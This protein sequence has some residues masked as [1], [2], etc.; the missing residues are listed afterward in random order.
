[1]KKIIYKIV[2][3]IVCVAVPIFL[4]L[5]TPDLQ[6]EGK[7]LAET[8]V[9]LVN[10]DEGIKVEDRQY[11]FGQILTESFV[12][13]S[14]FNAKNNN[15]ADAFNALENGSAMY[16]IVFD[17]DF[18][19][20]INSYDSTNQIKGKVE[21]YYNHTYDTSLNGN[22]QS[23]NERNRIFEELQNEISSV[24]TK[25][26]VSK[27]E[28][29]KEMLRKDIDSDIA[30]SDGIKKTSVQNTANIAGAINSANQH[31][32]GFKN[33]M[34]EKIAI[35]DENIKNSKEMESGI[36]KKAKENELLVNSSEDF[37]EVFKTGIEQN[38]STNKD[39]YI[40]SRDLFMGENG[41]HS[42]ITKTV[43]P[44]YAQYDMQY[45]HNIG[46]FLNII[47][48]DEKGFMNIALDVYEE[49][50]YTELKEYLKSM[51]ISAL[52]VETKKINKI[53]LF[54]EAE[55]NEIV[56]NA[57]TNAA[58]VYDE[59]E[60]SY[61]AG[62]YTNL[63]EI[64]QGNKG[65]LLAEI[66]EEATKSSINTAVFQNA[67]VIGA[68][69]LADGIPVGMVQIQESQLADFNAYN[70]FMAILEEKT[71]PIQIPYSN[72]KCYYMNS[73]NNTNFNTLKNII[74]SEYV[75]YGG[76]YTA[77]HNIVNENSL[78]V[79]GSFYGLS[80]LN[81]SDAKI[82]A[83]LKRE[84]ADVEKEVNLLNAY[85]S[86]LFFNALEKEAVAKFN[87]KFFE[88]GSK[89][90]LEFNDD[91]LLFMKTNSEVSSSLLKEYEKKHDRNLT[92]LHE[93]SAFIV[94]EYNKSK[95]H[96]ASII[97][98]GNINLSAYATMSDNNRLVKEENTQIIEHIAGVKKNNTNINGVAQK[99]NK[100][101]L[102]SLKELSDANAVQ[103]SFV[104]DYEKIL[105]VANVNGVSNTNFFDFI[106]DPI[107][108][109]KQDIGMNI[110]TTTSYFIIFWL[111]AG[112]FIINGL[113]DKF[114]KQFLLNLNQ[115]DFSDN[116]VIGFFN[117]HLIYIS[118]L[119]IF[120]SA[121]ALAIVEKFEIQNAS[122]F[123][124]EMIVIAVLISYIMRSLIKKSRFI[125]YSIILF[126]IAI[127][128]IVLFASEGNLANEI[129]ALPLITLDHFIMSNIYEV[130]Y[131]NAFIY[132]LVIY[133]GIA[134]FIV[135][136]DFVI[137]KNNKR[138]EL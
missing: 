40:M 90:M 96:N 36:V 31:I 24:Y 32:S 42:Y 16:V 116:K 95:E 79:L 51:Q 89:N 86:S 101:Y 74:K 73:V 18:S 23:E 72:N 55:V 7:E 33:E 66:K 58:D 29:T 26:I 128:Y 19:K 121:Y 65:I 47:D 25:T 133:I 11:N 92:K 64:Y 85:A 53:A 59:N 20:A 98:S 82:L 124:G 27:V 114:K 75:P 131:P 35:V 119:I 76:G 105:E 60:I 70:R 44:I 112:I 87:S 34:A 120:G 115:K 127:M 45:K 21:Y 129:L 78:G 5:Q 106:S 122:I 15:F 68:S 67:N 14:E 57:Y 1:M 48:I 77:M 80:A 84:Y 2:I 107:A 46:Q 63:N 91:A 37:H 30:L 111:F 41:I 71:N 54:T 126:V 38:Y 4:Y 39:D 109:S 117:K 102:V 52:D 13:K 56:T 17:R 136:V 8:T 28:E 22:V 61:N 97:E 83:L 10:E 135:L 113:Y 88:V 100:D 130:T 3:M 9:I 103:E 12:K 6:S 132:A 108:Y 43:L 93:D 125:G 94:N 104:G 118:L 49:S 138:K 69:P 99:N 81:V 137:S 110:S 134:L 50:N 62:E 123:I